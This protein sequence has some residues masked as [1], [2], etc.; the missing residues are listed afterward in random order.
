MTVGRFGG[1]FRT[2]VRGDADH[3]QILPTSGNMGLTRWSPDFQTILPNVAESWSTNADSSEYTV[4]LRAKVKWSDGAPFTADDILFF[5]N[6][7]LPN[8]EFFASPPTQ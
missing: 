7:L 2:V 3:N 6:D 1:T 8:R 5:V 4:K